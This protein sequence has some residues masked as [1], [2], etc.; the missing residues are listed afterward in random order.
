[1]LVLEA[2]FFIEFSWVERRCL[3]G[4]FLDRAR[5]MVNGKAIGSEIRLTDLPEWEFEGLGIRSVHR[6]PC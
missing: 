5:K 1:M 2:Y 4:F 6:N 3:R